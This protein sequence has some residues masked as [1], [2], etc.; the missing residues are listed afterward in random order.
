MPLFQAMQSDRIALLRLH[1][2]L[3]VTRASCQRSQGQDQVSGELR[4]DLVWLLKIVRSLAESWV[5]PGIQ[6]RLL[7]WLH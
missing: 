4:I 5:R 6:E 1:W 3:H 7:E 2:Y